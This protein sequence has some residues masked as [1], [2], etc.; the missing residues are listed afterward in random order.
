MAK[1]QYTNVI[2]KSGILFSVA[3]RNSPPLSLT[4]NKT[5]KNMASTTLMCP[6]G[7]QATSTYASESSTE[8]MDC[9]LYCQA[10]AEDAVS[11]S[12][13]YNTPSRPPYIATSIGTQIGKETTYQCDCEIG[14]CP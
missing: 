3:R 10:A 13:K 6:S 9:G 8:E 4:F 12:V 2:A 14:L 11:K 7:D 5:K 1:R